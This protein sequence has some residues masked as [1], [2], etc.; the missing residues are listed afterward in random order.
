[1]KRGM[2]QSRVL[3]LIMWTIVVWASACLAGTN[4]TGGGYVILS[5]TVSRGGAPASGGTMTLYQAA[6]QQAGNAV[7]TGATMTLAGGFL[8]VVDEAAPQMAFTSPDAS[9]SNNGTIAIAGT[10]FDENGAAW[11]VSYGPGATPSAWKQISS[12]AANITDSALASWDAST[13]WGTYTIRIQSADD[14]GNTGTLLR[15]INIWNSETFSSTIPADQWTMIALPGIP[16]NPDPAGFLGSARY[17]LQ[18]W[19]PTAA[20]NDKGLKYAITF[21]ITAGDAF[22]VKPYKT[23]ITY[24]VNAWVP[25]TTTPF[26]KR[27]EAGW[28]QIGAPFNH[29]AAWSQYQFKRDGDASAVTMAAAIASSWIDSNFYSYSAT[30]YQAHDSS[31]TLEPFTGY[32]VY[33]QTPGTLILDPGAG[34]TGGLARPVRKVFEWKLRVVAETEDARDTENYIGILKGASETFGSEDSAEPPTIEPFVSA[35][36]AHPDWGRAAGR[37]A[38]DVRPPASGGAAATH[39]W[40]LVVTTSESGQEFTLSLP[41]VETLP[42][43]YDIRITDNE[44]G[45]E[46]DPRTAPAR[47]FISGPGGQRAFT[48]TAAKTAAAAGTATAAH[49]F[50]AGWSLFSVPLE[51]SDTDARDQLG[52]GLL[53]L[54]LYQYYDRKLMDPDSSEGVDIQAGIGY[55]AYAAAPVEAQF[56]GRP[57]PESV[58]VDIPLAR[59]WNIIGNPFSSEVAFG[60]NLSMSCSEGSLPLSEA[61]GAGWLQGIAYGYDNETDEYYE[62]GQGGALQPWK[63][64]AIKA[65]TACV[66]TINK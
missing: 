26:E 49:V 17:E 2:P 54:R 23:P 5:D 13:L 65:L 59:G 25:D 7:A 60:D 44:T 62:V 27:L 48:I 61:V 32:F 41:D 21:P 53:N 51:T 15:T 9:S 33:A 47:T 28:N 6:G 50:P 11:T 20:D 42:A 1:M 55:W 29:A 3:F 34:R 63:G 19:D 52:G 39:V 58:P 24:S 46:Y 12:G 8:G 31:Q 64:Y 40:P 66:L 16:Q 36:F 43:N 4:K 56:H 38:T 22:W 37:F 45:A 14:R 10:A 18:R 35:H 30:G 57:A